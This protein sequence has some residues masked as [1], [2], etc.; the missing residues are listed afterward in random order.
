ML[1]LWS[2]LNGD[3]HVQP[4]EVTFQAGTVGGVT[5][6]PDLSFCIARVGD[7]AM[8][9]APTG[10]SAN[11]TPLYDLAKGQTLAEGVQGPA[12]S[13]GDQVLARRR[14]LDRP[15]AGHRAL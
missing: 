10:I 13:G 14:W 2:D 9:F 4:E 6:M 5:V 8:R 1:F 15:D 7:K 3:A 12:S 11:G